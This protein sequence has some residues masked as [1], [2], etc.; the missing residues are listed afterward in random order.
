MS[1][2]FINLYF[3]FFVF[4]AISQSKPIDLNPKDTVEYKQSYGISLGL[5]LSRIITSSLAN[6]Y[7]GFEIV[8]DYR[9]TQ[10][11][12]I[13]AELGNEE[14]TRQEDLFNFTTSGSYLKV[15]VNKNNYANWYGERNLIYLGGRLAFSTFENTLN[16]YQYF[17][18][19]R[20]WNPEDFAT[21]SD[22]PEKFSGLSATWLEA[23]FGTKVELFS[24]IYMGASIRLGIILAQKEDD[25]LPNLWIPGFNKVTDDSRFGVGYNYSISYFLPLYKKKNKVNKKIEQAE[26][27]AEEL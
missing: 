13:A 24:N 23:V 7:S 15:G 1:R 18:T 27:E 26:K 8:A 4:L 2:F 12:Y 19:N 25:R 6:N 5:D 16:N 11:L 17:D 22:V 14:K 3:L 20:Y 9:L 10:S 21:G